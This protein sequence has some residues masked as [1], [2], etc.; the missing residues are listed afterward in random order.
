[1]LSESEL[2]TLLASNFKDVK[3]IDAS[4]FPKKRKLKHCFSFIE[5]IAG[6]SVTFLIGLDEAFPL[7]L[8][9][10][11]IKEYDSFTFI[12]HI[13]VDGMVC[14]TRDDNVFVD[15]KNIEGVL[16]ESFTLAKRTVETGLS[17]ENGDDFINEF[18]A[19]WLRSKEVLIIH[20]NLNLSS[21]AAQI[22]IGTRNKLMFAVSEENEYLEKVKKFINLEEKGITYQNAIL[23][24]LRKGFYPKVLRKESELTF[25][26]FKSLVDGVDPSDLK[27]LQKLVNRSTKTKEYVLVSFEQPDG[28]QSLI[29]FEFS[30]AA[31]HP[32]VAESFK[33]KIRPVSIQRLD[34][35]YMIR[36]GGNGLTFFDKKGLVIG[37]GSVGGFIIEEL[38][39]SGF[40][41]LTIVDNDVMSVDNS[42]R[43]YLG[44]EFIGKPKVDGI[45]RKIDRSFPH[46]NI[47]ALKGKIEKFID[48]K[49]IDFKD[50]QFIVVATGN[51][52]INHFLNE[53]ALEGFPQLPMCYVWN[54]P[55]GLGG[56]V[57]MTN[58]GGAGCYHCLY[59]NPFTYNRA[60]FAEKDQPRGFLKAISGCGTMY[61]PFS[62]IDSRMSAC[63]AVKK[64]IE[65]LSDSNARNTIF[66]WK[67]DGKLFVKEGFKVSPRFHMNDQ[68]LL[69]SAD[70]F[71]SSTCDVCKSA[72]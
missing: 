3:K 69:D 72:K 63:L 39:R 68:E 46:S 33:G 47:V 29:G 11:F 9:L 8:P 25:E 16:L 7:S 41:D 22:K 62:S 60:S 42:Y 64:V 67:G 23:F 70:K 6:Q 19:Y 4:A 49:K 12:P 54:E 65:V 61:T 48:D 52:T 50:Y 20:G 58:M 26:Y 5:D 36:R 55:Y 57:L 40:T 45:K 21:T 59:D 37:C 24:T 32:I 15:Y 43:H 53:L 13:E 51:V 2:L 14:Y 44:F 27:V 1:M 10:Y 30:G 71:V 17:G 28:V 18:E 31:K 38:I 34:K 35:S 66:S 56:H